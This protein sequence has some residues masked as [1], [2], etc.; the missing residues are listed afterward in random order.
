MNGPKKKGQIGFFLMVH[1]T[2]CACLR[3][4]GRRRGG[5]HIFW[6]S[7]IELFRATIGKINVFLHDLTFL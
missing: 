6:K 5:V 1:F 4:S 3:L 2:P 7:L